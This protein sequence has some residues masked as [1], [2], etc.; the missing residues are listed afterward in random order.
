MLE[1]DGGA[2]PPNDNVFEHADPS[3]M[4]STSRSFTIDN[5]R[6]KKNPLLYLPMT[7]NWLEARDGFSP[8]LEV[9]LRT[10]TTARLCHEIEVSMVVG[11]NAEAIGWKA[12]EAQ[13]HMKRVMQVA[14][15]CRLGLKSPE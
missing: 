3:P 1:D 15:E 14:Q 9:V 5:P 7:S 10:R 4:T 12:A 8:I 6:D 11:T 13:L 2:Q